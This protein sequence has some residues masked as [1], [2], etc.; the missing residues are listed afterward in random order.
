MAALIAAGCIS[1]DKSVASGPGL[2]GASPMLFSCSITLMM[3]GLGAEGAACAKRQGAIPRKTM[4]EATV[5]VR[6]GEG[7]RRAYAEVKKSP[8][9]AMG[10]TSERGVY[11]QEKTERSMSH[12]G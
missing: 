1:P 8:F 4:V 6:M 10:S 7:Y 2:A 9:A 5:R 12:A 3:R 11:L